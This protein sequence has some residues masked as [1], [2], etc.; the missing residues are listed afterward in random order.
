MATIEWTI[1]RAVRWDG[2]ECQEVELRCARRHRLRVLSDPHG[3]KLGA[4]IPRADFDA[5]VDAE[6]GLWLRAWGEDGPYEHRASGQGVDLEII[7]D[8][9]LGVTHETRVHV[10]PSDPTLARWTCSCG[11]GSRGP[12]SPTFAEEGADAHRAFAMDA[13]RRPTD[14]AVAQDATGK[15][16]QRPVRIARRIRAC[17]RSDYSTVRVHRRGLGED[18]EIAVDAEIG[19]WIR[20]FGADDLMRRDDNGRGVSLM[21]LD[22]L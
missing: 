8:V 3:R 18:F 1:E 2:A 10:K 21:V 16:G 15:W 14:I 20:R 4:V 17:A 11:T 19:L 6:L 12:L 13:S 9:T 22:T 7:E 5:V